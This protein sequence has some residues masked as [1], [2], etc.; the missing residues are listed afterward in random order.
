MS[1]LNDDLNTLINEASQLKNVIQMQKNIQISLAEEKVQLL[2]EIERLKHERTLDTE[3]LQAN[4]TQLATVI[5]TIKTIVNA[6]IAT[7]E[8]V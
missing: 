7:A 4:I 3:G 2:A 6:P 5:E 1:V 8:G